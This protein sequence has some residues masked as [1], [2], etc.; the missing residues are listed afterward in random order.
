MGTVAFGSTSLLLPFASFGELLFFDSLEGAFPEL[1]RRGV[2][3]REDE[4]E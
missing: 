3:D 1:R 2:G 4:L